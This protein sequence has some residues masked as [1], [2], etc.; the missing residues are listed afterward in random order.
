M[1]GMI[2]TTQLNRKGKKRKK[3]NWK[4]SMFITGLLALSVSHFLIFWV[5]MNFET[6][7]MTFFEYK[8]YKGMAEFVG[9]DGYV[10]LFKEFFIYEGHEANLNIFLNTFRAITINLIIFPIALYTAYAFYKKVYGEKF[11]R[12]IFYLPSVISLV[13]LTMAYRNMFDGNVGGPV[14]E[15]FKKMG[16]NT[17]NW[18]DVNLP[19]N[20]QIW[21]IIYIFCVLMGLGTNVILMSGAMLR[22]PQDIPEAL[23]ID[24]CGYFREMFSVTVPLIMPTITT[25]GIAIFTSVFGFMMQPMLIAVSAGFENSV[26]TL[27]WWMFNLVQSGDKAS[28]YQAATAGIM[29]SAF[30]MPIIL[31]IRYV[32]EKVTPDVDF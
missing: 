20:T 17:N 26:M 24:G 3:T 32:L 13:A 2:K 19:N 6:V 8:K 14:A 10:K 11:F 31:V 30:M 23:Q 21:P 22:I 9:F 1:D 15:L 4:R 12:V 5:Y 29:F 18:L 16:A 7:R 28:Q 27:P 25:W